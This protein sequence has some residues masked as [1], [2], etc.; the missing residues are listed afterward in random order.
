MKSPRLSRRRREMEQQGK[1]GVF[2]GFT[3]E[4]ARCQKIFNGT[5]RGGPGSSENQTATSGSHR[6]A[7]VINY[8]IFSVKFCGTTAAARCPSSIFVVPEEFQREIVV[9]QPRTVAYGSTI[10]P[11]SRTI[12]KRTF[13]LNQSGRNIVTHGGI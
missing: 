5:V 3:I 4:R 1:K 11:S 13:Y 2:R 8:E 10:L 9:R 7:G 6:P 12:V